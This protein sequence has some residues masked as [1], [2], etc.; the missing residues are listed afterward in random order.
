[1]ANELLKNFLQREKA[2][3]GATVFIESIEMLLASENELCPVKIKE[4]ELA[5]QRR[6]LMMQMTENSILKTQQENFKAMIS[7]GQNTLKSI[8][9]ING[10][11]TVAFIAF[12]NNNLSHFLSTGELSVVYVFIWEALISF[13]VGT[14]LSGMGVGASYFA[15][16]DYAA[17]FE[18]QIP[19]I[20]KWAQDG[21]ELNLNYKISIWHIVTIIFCVL[22][23]LCTFV[24]IVF[25]AIGFSQ[26][27]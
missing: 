4:L 24:G 1:M 5:N 25:C 10:G 17:I 14:L 18:R 12:M 27:F 3:G 16:G 26:L 19:I 9:M 15:Q 20:R 7:M 21:G 11:A 13:G 23:Y 22:A 8:I 2:N 6:L